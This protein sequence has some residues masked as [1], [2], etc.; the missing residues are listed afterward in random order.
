MKSALAFAA[1]TIGWLFGEVTHALLPN[2]KP[3]PLVV[4]IQVSRADSVVNNSSRRLSVT[5]GS[6]QI[7]ESEMDK[8]E[9]ALKIKSSHL[10]TF[11]HG[12]RQT[13]F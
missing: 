7:M 3:T 10:N 6:L 5:E 13:N 2:P 4:E 11:S 8:M 1:V 12:K 9:R